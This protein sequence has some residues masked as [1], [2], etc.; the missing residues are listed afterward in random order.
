M[1]KN[2]IPDLL[3]DIFGLIS[4]WNLRQTRKIDE[5][6]SEDVR[7]VNTKIDREWRN[8][9]VLSRLKVGIPDNF[10]SDLIKVVEFLAG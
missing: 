4:D 3:L 2:H 5:G 6:E 7:R 9:E 10:I 8:S 1:L